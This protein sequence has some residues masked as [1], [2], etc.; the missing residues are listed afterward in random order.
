MNKFTPFLIYIN[1]TD[2]LPNNNYTVAYD[3]R[4]L[5]ILSGSGTLY[6][7]F[8]N[9]ELVPETFAY[10]PSGIKYFPKSNTE[11]KLSFI[12]VNFD[13]T[14][15][16]EDITQT[17]APVRA[18]EFSPIKEF[19]SF[20]SID[21]DLFQKPFIIENAVF[22]KNNL[23]RLCDIY[24]SY[25]DYEKELSS[26]ILKLCILEILKYNKHSFKNKLVEDIKLFIANNFSE[27]KS[28]SY[29]ANSFKYHEY[30]LNNLFKKHTGITIHQFIIDTRLKNAEELLARSDSSIYEIAINCGFVNANHFSRLFKEKKG[31][32]PLKYRSVSR[33]I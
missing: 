7:E 29:I 3:C 22:L 11:D 17:L 9:Y 33:N 16:H 31:V 28:N 24:K 25:S 21:D 8:G 6:T 32:S 1:K 30:Y 2:I 27:I 15:I 13:F 12:T 10:Y 14:D 5:Y 18:S 20:H 23:L 4:M 19:P 26:T